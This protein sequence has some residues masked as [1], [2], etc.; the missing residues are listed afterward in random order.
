M[1]SNSISYESEL[2]ANWMTMMYFFS[3]LLFTRF[4]HCHVKE[5]TYISILNRSKKL[6]KKQGQATISIDN[7]QGECFSRKRWAYSHFYPYCESINTQ[8]LLKSNSW[9]NVQMEKNREDGCRFFYDSRSSEMRV[10]AINAKNIQ[11]KLIS[12]MLQQSKS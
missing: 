12:E 9:S 6:I 11:R 10:R 2:P 7:R 3:I 5:V 4:F 1:K 8:K